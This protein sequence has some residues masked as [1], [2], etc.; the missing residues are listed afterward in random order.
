MRQRRRGP[1]T[2]KTAIRLLQE[3]AGAD[4]VSAHD[5]AAIELA[6]NELRKR[7]RATDFFNALRGPCDYDYA[8]LGFEKLVAEYAPTATGEDI[9]EIMDRSYRSARARGTLDTFTKRD[10]KLW[11][12]GER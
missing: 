1:T 6:I 7:N 5:T 10:S 11:K 3:L 4:N 8:I 12:E 9:L 2:L